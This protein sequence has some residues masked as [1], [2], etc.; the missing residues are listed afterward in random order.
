MAVVPLHASALNNT[1]SDLPREVKTRSVDVNKEIDSETCKTEKILNKLK[2]RLDKARGLYEEVQNDGDIIDA[3]HAEH[4]ERLDAQIAW[5]NS[6]NEELR[7][8]LDRAKNAW[9][10]VELES[11]TENAQQAQRIEAAEEEV[12]KLKDELSLLS[13]DQAQQRHSLPSS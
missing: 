3:K 6:K 13:D 9:A 5:S 4:V 7:L 2:M 8:E 1:T 12:Q 10:T 11:S